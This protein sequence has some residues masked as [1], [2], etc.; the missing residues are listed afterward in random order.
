[1]RPNGPGSCVHVLGGAAMRLLLSRK[2]FI[3]NHTSEQLSGPF[4]H[5]WHVLC[6]AKTHC[7]FE[8]ACAR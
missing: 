4:C 8:N 7:D 2:I 1:M 5:E 3:G 6:E